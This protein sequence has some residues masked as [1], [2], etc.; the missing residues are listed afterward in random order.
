M[1]VTLSTAA[2]AATVLAAV[3]SAFSAVVI[4]GQNGIIGYCESKNMEPGQFKYT[5]SGPP[6]SM[7]VDNPS[8][9]YMVYTQDFS[10]AQCVDRDGWGNLINW[11]TLY[12]CVR[13]TASA[14]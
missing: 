7:R 6:L 2:V 9:T 14:C 12:W 13:Q 4:Y 5:S 8:V 3:P 1:K 11:P 10:F